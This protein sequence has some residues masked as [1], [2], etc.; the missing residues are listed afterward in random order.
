MKSLFTLMPRAMR[1]VLAASAVCALTA[2]SAFASPIMTYSLSQNASGVTTAAGTVTVTANSNDELLVS[3]TLA[4][5]NLIVNTGGPHTPF[6]F[7]SGMSIASNAITIVSPVG[8]ACTPATSPCFTPT[9]AAGSA[10]PFGSLNEA[11][12][13]SGGNGTGAGNKGP[14]SFTI[15]G[16]NFGVFDTTTQAYD[17][18]TAN[19]Y[20]AIFGADL[21]VGGNTGTWIA[22]SGSCTSG[23]TVVSPPGGA[24]VPEPASFTVFGSG[25]VLL[26][27]MRRKRRQAECRAIA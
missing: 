7:N 26:G 17:L 11:F 2:G 15:D 13:Y 16:T 27:L 22:T 5:T 21:S 20:G 18:F 23:C 9:Y 12:S 8:S 14:L 3:F 19:S 10:T 6:A 25:L 24:A 4:G 1:F